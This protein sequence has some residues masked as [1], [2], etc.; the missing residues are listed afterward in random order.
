MPTE[1]TKLSARPYDPNERGIPAAEAPLQEAAAAAASQ[2]APP[3]YR[4]LTVI[5]ELELGGMRPDLW[6]GYFD[7]GLFEARIEAGIEPCTAPYPLA[8]ATELRGQGGSAAVS[9]L[10]D[11]ASASASEC[12]AG[13]P[14]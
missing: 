10:A 7:D 11:R 6:I 12:G 3:G 9:R 13:S 2:L 14:S 1:I 4:Q 5:P 8:I